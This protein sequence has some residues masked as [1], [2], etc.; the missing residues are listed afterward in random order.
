MAPMT[1]S[2]PDREDDELNEEDRIVINALKQRFPD[3]EDEWTDEQNREFLIELLRYNGLGRDDVVLIEDSTAAYNYRPMLKS[4][5]HAER[6]YKATIEESL[7]KALRHKLD[8]PASEVEELD[9]LPELADAFVDEAS[10]DLEADSDGG[11]Q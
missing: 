9:G 6:E 4:E 5:Y 10:A 11:D 7:S 2:L 3:D 1:P 8:V